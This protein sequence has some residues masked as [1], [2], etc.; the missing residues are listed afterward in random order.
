M[1]SDWARFGVEPG[2]SFAIPHRV[3]WSECDPFRHA[4]H[5]AYFEWFEEARNRYL[6]AVGLAP[7]SPDT[8]GP[9]IADTGIRYHRPLVYADEILVTARTVRL[10]HTSF[11]MEY[12]VWRDGLCALGRAVLILV[13]NATGEKTPLPPRNCANAFSP[14]T[15]DLRHGNGGPRYETRRHRH[16]RQPEARFDH[17]ARCAVPERIRADARRSLPTT[18]A[19]SRRRRERAPRRSPPGAFRRAT[20]CSA[21]RW[22]STRVTASSASRSASRIFATA[23]TGRPGRTLHRPTLAE[24]VSRAGGTAIAISNVSPG[25][26]Y[27]LDPDGFGWVYNPAGSFGP[28]RRPLPAGGGARD[29][30]GRRRRRRRDRALLRGSAPRARACNRACCGSRS[31][32]IR[33]ITPRSAR[34]HIAERSRAPTKMSTASPRPLRRSIRQARTSS[35]SSARITEWR[36]SR[37]PLIS[38]GY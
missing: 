33:A 11:D 28:G 31:R 25:A 9:V 14:A 17:A 20:A 34:Q 2:W 26:A 7:V 36:R 15:P 30:E 13:V 3:R 35:S 24:R 21:T 16:L 12:A 37:R 6:E 5:R 19:S 1:T 38:M 8:P 18:G 29:L 4:G 32:T 23:C 10:G 27:F 22:R